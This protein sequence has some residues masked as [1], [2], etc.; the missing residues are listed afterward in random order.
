MLH[1]RQSKV[2][3]TRKQSEQESQPSTI[4]FIIYETLS[5]CGPQLKQ[6]Y[7][8]TEFFAYYYIWWKVLAAPEMDVNVL[9][10]IMIK[11]AWR[12]PR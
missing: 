2:I 11:R 3:G 1:L 9:M 12:V 5:S 8:L 10:W 7:V 6:H 4:W